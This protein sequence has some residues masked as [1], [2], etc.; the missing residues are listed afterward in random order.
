M[1]LLLEGLRKNTSL[2]RIRTL[3][4]L[5]RSHQHQEETA[6]CAG[7]WM[8]EMERVGYRNR[9]LPLIRAER[10]GGPA[11]VSGLMRLPGSNNP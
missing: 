1:P 3:L 7:G 2:F 9:F 10:K 11:S 4:H 8:R 5:P 6:R